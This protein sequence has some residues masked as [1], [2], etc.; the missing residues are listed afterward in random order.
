MRATGGFYSKSQDRNFIL[1]FNVFGRAK[2]RKMHTVLV[3]ETTKAAFLFKFCFPLF[4]GIR[5]LNF[6]LLGLSIVSAL[7]G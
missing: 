7:Y 2:K 3:L 6:Y 5:A 4:F 1:L